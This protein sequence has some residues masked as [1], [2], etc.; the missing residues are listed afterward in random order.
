MIIQSVGFGGVI[1]IWR[2][3]LEIPILAQ[4]SVRD[5]RDVPLVCF[6]IRT[7]G[8]PLPPGVEFF[9]GESGRAR[10]A[11]RDHAPTEPAVKAA[12]GV[13]NVEYLLESEWQSD[14]IV[15]G[16]GMEFW[17]DDNVPMTDNLVHVLGDVVTNYSKAKTSLIKTPLRFVLWALNNHQARNLLRRKL[18]M[19]S[20]SIRFSDVQQS[21]WLDSEANAL[22]AKLGI[23]SDFVQPR[24]EPRDSGRRVEDAKPVGVNV[25]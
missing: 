4:A 19:A 14:V 13:E 15:I 21:D 6:Q 3:I 12:I 7:A 16:Y 22:A 10:A 8:R 11:I 2:R 17:I 18:G 24:S 5:C 25:A 20:S 1:R 9:S 23:P